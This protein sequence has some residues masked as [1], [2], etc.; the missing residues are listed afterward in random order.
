LI[1]RELI[2]PVVSLFHSSRPVAGSSAASCPS[3]VC[4]TIMP[5]TTIGLN[6][7]AVPSPAGYSQAICNWATLAGVIWSSAVYCE[8]SEPPRYWSQAV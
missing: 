2:L 8:L 6:C 4:T 5:P 1:P 3:P 7:G